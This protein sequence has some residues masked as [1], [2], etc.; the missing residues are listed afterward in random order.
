MKRVIFSDGHGEIEVQSKMK[1]IGG[2]ERLEQ[3]RAKKQAELLEDAVIIYRIGRGSHIQT[4][5]GGDN[6]GD[7]RDLE[8]F[9]SKIKIK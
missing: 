2:E 4:L 1:V 3:I 6:L 7:I 5:P 9:Q 8:Y